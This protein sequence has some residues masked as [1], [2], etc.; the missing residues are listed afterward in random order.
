MKRYNT[1]DYSILKHNLSRSSYK[2]NIKKHTHIN[3]SRRIIDILEVNA[4]NFLRNI[5]RAIYL[6]APAKLT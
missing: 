2:H 5:F 6:Y 4:D 3:G 1:W